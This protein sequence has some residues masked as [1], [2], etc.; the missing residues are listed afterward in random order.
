MTKNDDLKYWLALSFVKDIGPVTF[1]KLLSAFS[2]PRKILQANL[3]ELADIDDISEL[4]VKNICEF[5]EWNR[6]E[7]EIEAINHYAVSQGIRVITYADSEYPENLRQIDDSPI[8]LY[9]KGNIIKED[10]Y[11]VAIVGSRDMSE[12]GKRVTSAIAS[13]LALCGLTIVS[14]M[15][16]GI[17]T[18]AHIEALKAGGRSI[19]V[20]GCGIDSPYPPENIKLFNSLSESGCVISEFP[21]GTPPNRENFPKRNRLISGLSFGVVVAEAAKNSGS[22]ITANCALDQG[23][24]VFAVPGNITSRHSE[25]TNSLIKK[26]AKLIQNANDILEELSP[27]LKS[28]INF[29]KNKDKDIFSKNHGRLEIT[30]EEKAICYVLGSEPKHIDLIIRETK[31]PSARLLGLLLDLEIKGVVKQSGGQKFYLNY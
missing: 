19:A 14:G 4:R 7:R 22:L 26:G 29:S 31:M 28:F 30:D 25:G 24:E 6:V 21:F 2:S 13:E 12:Y 15:A 5:D 10:K 18:V 11:A 1:K 3:N 8:L 20:L 17:D 27:Q 23:R 16:R 9:A